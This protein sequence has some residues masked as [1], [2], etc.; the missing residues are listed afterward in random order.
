M[1]T[2]ASASSTPASAGGP[3]QQLIHRKLTAALQPT[4][5]VI[6]N[7]SHM[8]SGPRDAESHFKVTIVAAAFESLAI[9]ARHRTVN[10]ALADELKNGIHA[11]SITARTPHQW[12]ADQTVAKSPACLGGSKHDKK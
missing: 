6:A 11:L 2:A 4:H 12:E 7:E 10:A 8:H 3:M 9:L 5:L 1:S